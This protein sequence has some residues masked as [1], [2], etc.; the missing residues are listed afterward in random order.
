M[1]RR[2]RLLVGLGMSLGVRLV[3]SRMR[4]VRLVRRLAFLRVGWR[5]SLGMWL[6]MSRWEWM[7][8]R[9]GWC[10]GHQVA[11]VRRV[12]RMWL[13][14]LRHRGGLLNLGDLL[15]RLDRL[16]LL[17]RLLLQW[18]MAW[19]RLVVG[20]MRWV[21]RVRLVRNRMRCCMCCLVRLSSW[22]RLL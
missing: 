2:R 21:C 17:E 6:G 13:L 18:L 1:C 10:V 9:V 3:V 12:Y 14:D 19:V 7:R 15:D 11:I 22:V 8:M 20:G 16:L 5:D 4:L